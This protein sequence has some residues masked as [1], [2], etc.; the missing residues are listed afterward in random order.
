MNRIGV[1]SNP[2]S[3]QNRKHPHR[4][5]KLRELV[6]ERSLAVFPSTIPEM[7]G[8]LEKM[9]SE[10]VN[11]IAINGGDGTVHIA[12]S[13]LISIFGK[14]K[15]P[16]IAVLKGGTMNQTATNLKIR[17]NTFSILKRIVEKSKKKDSF[18][19]TPIPLLCVDGNKYGFMCGT[20]SVVDF[21]DIYHSSGNPSPVSAMKAIFK[22]ASSA[23]VK[24]HYFKKLFNPQEYVFKVNDY[25]Y[26]PGKYI[27]SM[28][29]TLKQVGL[30]FELMHRARQNKG[31]HF[32][33]FHETPGVLM[34]M[35]RAWKGLSLPPD[36][37][38]DAVGKSFTVHSETSFRY[39]L[40]G[41]IYSSE[42]TL[43]IETGPEINIVTE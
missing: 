25:S 11:I 40:D 24:G 1:I 31:A 22:L 15:L 37:V 13:R 35:I 36:T 42:G 21:M 18:S 9:R 38:D 27:A 10:C 33:A 17:G 12:L 30:G 29:S 28:I 4:L 5:E 3:K 14:D 7:D 43:K 8:A 34:H 23:V 41:D 26:R 16:D 2:Y 20:G 32:L 39:T 19:T 6:P